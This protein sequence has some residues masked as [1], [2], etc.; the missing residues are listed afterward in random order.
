MRS[1]G[2]LDKDI[3]SH[4]PQAPSEWCRRALRRGVQCTR[5]RETPGTLP[6]AARCVPAAIRLPHVL[7][8]REVCVACNRPELS[9]GRAA[10]TIIGPLRLP[11][12]PDIDPV[13]G[14]AADAMAGWFRV[15]FAYLLPPVEARALTKPEAQSPTALR[16]AVPQLACHVDE[17]HAESERLPAGCRPMTGSRKLARRC[18]DHRSFSKKRGTASQLAAS[19]RPPS[20][21]TRCACRC[22]PHERRRWA[23]LRNGNG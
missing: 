10:L 13:R 17:S 1:V 21:M 7:R 9:D 5:L 22:V 18:P 16:E 11:R 23:M 3:R 2:F 8:V 15:G 4:W 12:D 20:A 19:S 6:A 14:A